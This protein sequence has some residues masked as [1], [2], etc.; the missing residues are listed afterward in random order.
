MS[1]EHKNHS[2]SE[3]YYSSYDSEET[4]ESN[5]THMTPVFVLNRCGMNKDQL[6]KAFNHL[7]AKMVEEDRKNYSYSDDTQSEYDEDMPRVEWVSIYGKRPEQPH[8]IIIT[9]NDY[10]N[11]DIVEMGEVTLMKGDVEVE[12][13]IRDCPPLEPESDEYETTKVCVTGLPKNIDR[14]QLDDEIY[15]L[16]API[17]DTKRVI[18]PKSYERNG[19]IFLEMYDAD[20]AGLVVRVAKFV[21]FRGTYIKCDFAKKPKKSNTKR[22]KKRKKNNKKPRKS[23][24]KGWNTT[25][26]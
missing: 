24:P 17:A 6:I 13:E 21:Q 25:K 12:V 22:K 19:R 15:D 14:Q 11:Q 26:R 2:N 20:S 7:I 10:I 18:I 9:G 16:I 8:A 1:S 5:R 23:S 3:E 4:D